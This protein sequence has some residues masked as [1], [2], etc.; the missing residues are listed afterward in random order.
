MNEKDGAEE[1][2]ARNNI[3]EYQNHRRPDKITE[4]QLRISFCNTLVKVTFNLKLP[5]QML[6]YEQRKRGVSCPISVVS[7][8][9]RVTDLAI[10]LDRGKCCV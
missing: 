6:L 4:L 1:L 9:I 7:R 10:Q 5:T 8:A 2:T 3:N